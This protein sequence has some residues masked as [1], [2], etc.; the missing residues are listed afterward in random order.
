M[1][2]YY[3]K[4]CR[5]EECS[6]PKCAEIREVLREREG[7]AAEPAAAQ[8]VQ[9]DASVA[10]ATPPA[11][12]EKGQKRGTDDI[13]DDDIEAFE[14]YAVDKAQSEFI[15]SIS[16]CL[17]CD[18]YV[19]SDGFTYEKKTIE[20]WVATCANRDLPLTSP[21]TGDVMEPGMLPNR[22]LR[23]LCREFLERMK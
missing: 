16:H 22:T 1:L 8:A 7:V 6:V 5:G 20:E 10:A 3:A 2:Q 12:E 11:N 15:C 18:P 17:F 21:T 4:N 23:I 19:A 9:S 14:E 13:K